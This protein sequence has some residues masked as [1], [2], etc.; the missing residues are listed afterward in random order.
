MKNYFENCRTL[1]ELKA[2]YK[3]LAKKYHPDMGGDTATMQAIN[4]QY[5]AAFNNRM[6]GKATNGANTAETAADFI[7]VINAVMKM[8]G[9]ITLEI[10]G[11]WLWCSGDTRPVKEQLKAAG[12]RWASKK[13]MWYWHS[14]EYYKRSSNASMDAIRRKYGSRIVTKRDNDMAMA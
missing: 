13:R 3:R 12:F 9:N 7:N 2:E 5:E 14:G 8:G 10:V 11:N 6:N 4:A 1:D